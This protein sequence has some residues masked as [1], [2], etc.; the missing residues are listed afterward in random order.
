MRIGVTG[1][2]GFLGANFVSEL[3]AHGDPW[4]EVTAFCSRLRSNPLFDPGKVRVLPLD[5]LDRD[6]LGAAF[7][8]LDAVA[9]FAGKVDYRASEKRNVWDSD[10]LGALNVYEAVLE[11]GVGRLLNVSSISVLGSGTRDCLAREDARPWG[12]PAYPISFASASEALQAVEASRKGDYRFLSKV[13]VA[14]FDAKL[15]AREIAEV[16]VR[17]K[18]LPAVTIY[19]GTAVGPGDLHQAIS[20][21]V[22]SVWE[23]RLA[24]TLRGG[25]SFVSAGDF[26]KGARLAFEKGRPGED[27][28]LSGR[29]EDNLDYVDFAGQVAMAARAGGGKPGPLPRVMPRLPA[30]MAGAMLEGLAPKTGLSAGLVRS[31]SVRNWCSSAKARAGLGYEASP[32][33]AGAIAECRAFSLEAARIRQARA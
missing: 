8:G 23:G 19:P 28:V 6:A 4:L 33:L 18:G 12:D 29:D 21:L 17:E 20:T 2:F 11:A 13:R 9:H 5:I 32:G 27:F 22:D 30:V 7:R 25:T 10:V 14:Y 1:A 26:A 3:L 24:L 15:A 31:A 16:Y